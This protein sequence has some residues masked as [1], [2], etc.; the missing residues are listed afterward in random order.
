M[1]NIQA[2]ESQLGVELFPY[3]RLQLDALYNEQY[4]IIYGVEASGKSYLLA[5]YTALSLL[6]PFEKNK[7]VVTG[8]TF[9]TCKSIFETVEDILNK[10]HPNDFTFMRESDRYA[11]KGRYGNESNAYFLPL[12][13]GT[14]SR[15]LRPNMLIVDAED[16]MDQ[17]TL[18]AIYCG[19]QATCSNVLDRIKA[20]ALGRETIVRDSHQIVRARRA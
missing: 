12:G 5:V 10:T 4:P 7:I 18:N 2:V 20:K 6:Q 11:I 13:D 19:M 16:Q 3:Q 9:R 1:I 14:K 15:G 17:D 8:P